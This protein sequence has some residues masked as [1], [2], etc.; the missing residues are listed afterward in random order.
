MVFVTLAQPGQELGDVLRG[1]LADVVATA[2]SQRRGVPVQVTPV[3]LQR[4]RGQTPL[5]RQVVEVGRDG[6]RG[7]CQLSTSARVAAGSSCASATGWQVTWPS[8]VFRPRANDGSRRSA[9]RQPRLA[10]STT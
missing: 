8:W 7:G 3:R 10:I 1:D 5:D 6:L 4:V 2:G 9:S